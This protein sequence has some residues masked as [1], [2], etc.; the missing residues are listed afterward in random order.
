[1]VLALALYGIDNEP[2]NMVVALTFDDQ[3]S[4]ININS[5]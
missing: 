2:V 3:E 5:S 1:M 4:D